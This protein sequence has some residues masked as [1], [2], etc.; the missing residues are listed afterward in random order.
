MTLR[1]V[2]RP[3]PHRTTRRLAVAL[4]VAL[5][6]P[7]TVAVVGPASTATARP[8][9]VVTH[10]DQ[11][12]P[13]RVAT[14][15]LGGRLPSGTRAGAITEPHR[16]D[17]DLAVVGATWAPGALGGGDSVQ[18]R[19]REKGVWQS[20]EDM[21]VE[22][23]EHG[24]DPGTA[25][26]RSS[27]GSTLPVVVDGED[28]QVRVV[29][30]RATAPK[31][32]V[33][34]VDPGTSA[35]DA[36]VGDAVPGSASAATAR[37]TIHTRKDWGADESLK[38]STPDY[39]QVQAGFVHHTVGTNSYSSAQVPGI[40]R[41]IYDFHVNGRGWND[42]GYQ[43][44]V[45]RFGRIWEGRAGGVDKAVV[46]A[47]AQGYNSGS[48]GASVMGDF[49][50]ATPPAAVTTALA[51]LFAWKFSVHGIPATGRVV[52]ADK[53]FERIS[54][55]RDANQTSCPGARLYDRIPWLRTAVAGRL[56]TRPPS[57]VHRSVDGGGTPDLLAGTDGTS[58]GPTAGSDLQVLRSASPTPVRPGV[59]IGTGWNRLRLITPTPDLTGDG[60]PDVVAATSAGALRVYPGNGAGGFL[61]MRER[62]SGWGGITRVVATGDRTGDGRG[63]LLVVR[64]DGA[65]VLQVGDGAGW[66]TSA[67]VLATGF[68]AYRSVVD[69]GDVDGD[70]VGDLFTITTATQ[71]L[72]LH[73]GT[74]DGGV[75][76][77]VRWGAGWSGLD[78]LM[79]ADLDGDGNGGDLLTRQ[80]DGRM[81]SYYADV[82][83]HLP[84][85]NTFG[86][87]WGGLDSLSARVDWDG[88][89]VPDVLG[90]VG[91]TGD[92]RMYPGTG[93]RDFSPAPLRMSTGVADANLVR[94][95]GDV[96]GDGYADAVART[97][98]GD[99]VGLRGRGDGSF[100]RVSARIGTGWGGLNLIQPVGDYTNDGVPDLVGRLPDG[101]LKVY[102]MTRDFRFAWS[103]PIGTGW[104]GARSITATGAV[105]AD[106]NADVVVL[107][108]DGSIR[109]YRGTGPG[110]LTV[111]STVLTGQ[112]DLVGIVG[113]GDLTGDGVNDVVG[114]SSAGRLYVYPGNRSGGF[115]PRQLVRSP[116]EAPGVVI[117]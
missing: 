5:L 101:T 7:V 21:P 84:R 1:P 65:L 116:Q 94:I 56:G 8:A 6:A 83:G 54:G 3:S 24:P 33:F 47:Q 104:Q 111:Y 117:S 23:D 108:D 110:A 30:D 79:S 55:H 64:T 80:A 114:Q 74:R 42:I 9:P 31:V 10:H 70:G 71:V 25:E 86:S 49:T 12:A 93:Q 107:R 82:A 2:L 81:R 115:R 91:A 90:R 41:G 34:F 16:V 68:G 105:N 37:P 38:R 109:L 100:A 89:G 29:T 77:P 73:R 22:E 39:G 61:A 76:A 18:I 103:L 46:G 106:V 15:D 32:E 50:S 97:T 58:S 35:A 98:A 87:G 19:V 69:A 75:T 62:G 63:D 44:L 4:A 53:S 66:F 57:T 40:I 27:R 102:A 52:I 17:A 99:L 59:R 45:D 43:F 96:D 13:T 95:V 51:N 14:R 113:T 92:L 48:F 60:R 28:A 20:W 88:D 26:A 78:Q 72:E 85:V 67:R 11:V 36:G 112:T